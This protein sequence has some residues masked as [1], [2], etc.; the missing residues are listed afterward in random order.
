MATARFLARLAALAPAV[1]YL[2]ALVLIVA[3]LAAVPA[4]SQSAP[5]VTDGATPESLV[6]VAPAPQ[7]DDPF[8]PQNKLETI[9]S[10]A[11]PERAP[12]AVRRVLPAYPVFARLARLRGMVYARL[13][14]DETGKVVQ[15][16]QIRGHA[17]FR[18]AVKTAARQWEFAP[19]RQGDLA[20]RAW[21]MVPFSFER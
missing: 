8:L 12:T 7:D 11:V 19:A 17:A 6:A 18:E 10:L 5:A 21:V 15:V 16:G 4:H 14:V 1:A 13:L 20:V 2:A 9:A 3:M